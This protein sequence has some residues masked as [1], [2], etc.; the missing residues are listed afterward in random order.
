MVRLDQV[1]FDLE[2]HQD[3]VDQVAFDLED[4]LGQLE[5]DLLV[6]LDVFGVLAVVLFEEV[7]LPSLDQVV[8]DL[9]VEDQ[10][11]PFVEPV[12]E[13]DLLDGELVVV[14]AFA[15]VVA[16]D[17]E[18]AGVAVLVGALVSEV[19]LLDPTVK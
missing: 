13:V 17:S 1:V 7:D 3:R 19:A 16:V 5:V 4:L 6:R 12:V 8:R 9:V 15:L 10:V 2:G 18:L 11:W 14:V